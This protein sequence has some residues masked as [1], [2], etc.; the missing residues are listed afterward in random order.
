MDEDPNGYSYEKH[1][2]KLFA[3]YARIVK[4]A[5]IKPE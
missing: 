4:E 1:M 5:K 2:Q 3:K